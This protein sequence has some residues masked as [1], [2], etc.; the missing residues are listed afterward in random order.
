MDKKQ[1]CVVI[2]F[3]YSTPDRKRNLFYT[4]KYYNRFLKDCKIIIVEQDSKTDMSEVSGCYHKHFKVNTNDDHFNRGFLFN[5][6]YNISQS[7]FCADYIIFGDADCLIEK[8]VLENIEEYYEYFDDYFVLPF[9]DAMYYMSEDETK[10]FVN[11]EDINTGNNE[12]TRKLEYIVNI[13]GGVNILSAKNFYCIGGYDER[14]KG[15]GAEDDAFAHKCSALNLKKYRI[16]AE[17]LHLHHIYTNR[18]MGHYEK[19]MSFLGE[20]W[21]VPDTRKYVD[22][23]GYKHL[24]RPCK[25]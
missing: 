25:E 14:F 24:A 1:I 6:G 15:W 23:L 16:D 9:K 3:R 17:L 19:N 11:N 8:K 18:D 21:S 4:I 22:F 5:I 7:S 12:K 2:P 10:N 20:Y 13:H